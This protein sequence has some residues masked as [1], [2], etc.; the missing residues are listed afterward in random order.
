MFYLLRWDYRALGF[1][2]RVQ[3]LG[4][5]AEAFVGFSVGVGVGS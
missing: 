5:Q 3:G 1:G 4:L 2:F